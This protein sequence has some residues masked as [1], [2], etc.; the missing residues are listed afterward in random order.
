MISKECF[1]NSNYTGQVIVASQIGAH[2]IAKAMPN[3]DYAGYTAENG[4]VIFAVSDGLG[5]CKKSQIG[6]QK[7]VDTVLGL[8]KFDIDALSTLELQELICS[9]WK[10]AVGEVIN[11]YS[12]TLRFVIFTITRVIVGSI[13]DGTTLIDGDEFCSYKSDAEFS[14]CTF[15]LCGNIQN[16]QILSHSTNADE[17]R[18][19]IMTDGISNE[20]RVDAE[21]DLLTYVASILKTEKGESE[22]VEWI[23]S[24]SANNGDDKTLVAAVINRK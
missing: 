11:D 16:F 12:A 13:G 10:K 2:H 23:E 19:L 6:S 1:A 22:I 15:A 21:Q 18:L 20:I 8:T 4:N 9:T 24:L 14:N 7:A 5:S 3:Q 17:Y